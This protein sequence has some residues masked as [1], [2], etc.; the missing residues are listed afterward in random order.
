[1]LLLIAPVLMRLDQGVSEAQ[2]VSQLADKPRA[3]LVN[4]LHLKG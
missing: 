1:M 3:I 4:H 2:L